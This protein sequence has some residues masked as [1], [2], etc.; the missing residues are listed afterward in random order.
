[1]KKPLA[2]FEVSQT[3]TDNLTGVADDIRALYTDFGLRPYRVF[4]TWVRWTRDTNADGIVA[5]T[6]M[7]L[8]DGERGVGRAV[9]VREEEVL[10]TPRIT[11]LNAVRKE[12]DVTGLTEKG[13]IAIDQ[14]SPRYTEDFLMGLVAPYVDPSDP[15][16]LVTDIEFFWEVQEDRPE[17]YQENPI[18]APRQAE[19][20]PRRRFHPAGTPFRAADQFQWIVPLTRADADRARDG[21]AGES[22]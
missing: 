11:S 3:L 1:M 15:N 9:V 16:N 19:R 14:I 2:D 7:D 6:E 20:Q 10:P 21:D 13:G 22:L 5:G 8:L 12:L 17:C 4:L 18:D